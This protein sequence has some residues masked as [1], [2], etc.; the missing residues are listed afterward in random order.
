MN[1]PLLVIVGETAT[2]KSKIA[3]EVAKVLNGE[4]ICADSW[5]V[6]RE[7]NVGTSKPS[8][9]DQRIVPHHLLD[10]VAADEEF[11][12]AIYKRLAVE[13]ISEINDRAKLP[14]MVGGSGLYIDSVIYNYGFLDAG[15]RDKRQDYNNKTVEELQNIANNSG[16]SMDSIDTR[17]KRRIIRFIESNGILPTKEDLRDNTLVIGIKCDSFTL[18]ANIERR[19]D[20]MIKSGLEQ[21]VR[22]L[23][24]KYGWDCEAL[25]GVG[26][27]Q[28]RGFVEGSQSL[29]ETREQI[30]NATLSLAKKQR[31]WFKRNKSIQWLI[32]PVNTADIVELATTLLST[33]HFN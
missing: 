2:G 6:R 24:D 29:S 22:L 3:I 23:V 5:T 14:I 25:R 12:A 32:Q 15:D 20:L 30:V 11:T 31:T 7:L 16:L 10:I 21:E 26:Y 8:T 1:K 33:N 13:K 4:I 9:K 18:K 27:K 19:V 28:W 17:N